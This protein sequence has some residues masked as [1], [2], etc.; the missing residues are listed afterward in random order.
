MAMV[1]GLLG[2]DEMHAACEPFDRALLEAAGEPA[3]V[4]VV[5]TAVV[6]NGSVPMAMANAR[7]YFGR[8]LGRRVVEVAL[9]RRSDGSRPE[10]VEALR[11]SALTFIIG[12]DP[13]YLLDSLLDTPAWDA[14]RQALRS[15][16]ALA[17][18]SA[19]AMVVCE[20]L[21][22]RSRNPSP[23]R[24]HARQAL[25]LMP[26]LVLIPH[27]N[28]FGHGW[29]QAARREARGRDILG[30]D[31]STG[32]VYEGGWLAR[33]PGQVKLWR[34][35]AEPPLVRTDGERLRLRAPRP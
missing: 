33:G 20:T 31:E 6:Q 14:M 35:G 12:G 2:G 16:A 23:S 34:R 29:L 7:R 30:L 9:H 26:G 1:L 11:S 15:G 10:V 32:V 24:R 21:L 8:R 5:T 25:S 22:L 28:R 13:G 3:E 18:S 4:R 19:G 17:G 27:L